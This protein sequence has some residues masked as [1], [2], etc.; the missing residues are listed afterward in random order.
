MAPDRVQGERKEPPVRALSLLVMKESW[1]EAK[2][3]QGDPP[4]VAV[5]VSLL[6]SE[7]CPL[8]L[9]PLAQSPQHLPCRPGSWVPSELSLRR[10][11]TAPP[12]GEAPD[13]PRPTSGLPAL[14]HQVRGWP[15]A[16]PWGVSHW[17]PSFALRRRVLRDGPA[18]ETPHPG[19]QGAAESKRRAC[20]EEAGRAAQACG[21][22]PCGQRCRGG[23]GAA[24]I[25]GDEERHHLGAG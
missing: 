14:G 4:P 13:R 15:W 12:V 1:G 10:H 23:S 9:G 20:W 21:R 7:P 11:G 5:K 18:P 3:P 24:L 17:G 8:V 22:A 25:E 19:P 6:W 16:R 2:A